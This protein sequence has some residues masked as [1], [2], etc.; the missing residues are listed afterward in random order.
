MTD[1]HAH[2]VFQVDDGARNLDESLAMLEQA[3]N[4]G[5]ENIVA[6]PHITEAATTAGNE[7]IKEHFQIIQNEIT[8][9]NLS[10]NIYLGSEIYYNEFVYQWKEAAWYTIN[11]NQKYLLFELPMF[12]LPVNVSDFIF[13][14]KLQGI[15]PILAHPERYLYLHKRSELLVSWLGQGCLLQMNAGSITG[16][17]GKRIEWFSRKLLSEGLFSFVASDA[18]DTENRTFNTLNEAKKKTEQ[19]LDDQYIDR[20][21]TINPLSAVKGD[22]VLPLMAGDRIFSKNKFKKLLDKMKFLP[23]SHKDLN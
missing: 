1:I 9:K 10:V 11:N 16:A 13:Q 7:R 18:H 3:V 23:K 12:Y 15:T 2:F 8:A 5:I 20:L 6:T 14:C 19:F 21:F 17:F 22:P 4:A